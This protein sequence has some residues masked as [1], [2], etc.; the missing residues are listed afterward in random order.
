P[1]P[2]RRPSGAGG[3]AGLVVCSV[4]AGDDTRV[5]LRLDGETG[6]LHVAGVPS[7]GTPRGV[8]LV[9]LVGRG[10][11]GEARLVGPGPGP[12][13]GAG[14]VGPGGKDLEDHGRAFA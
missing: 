10:S 14:S 12:G 3:P 2:G 7:G 9:T 1:A 4:L 6:Y 13:G 5:F 11:D 8:A